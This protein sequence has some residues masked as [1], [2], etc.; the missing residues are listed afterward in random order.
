MGTIKSNRLDKIST[1][2]YRHKKNTYN[3]AGKINRDD[4]IFDDGWSTPKHI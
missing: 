2:G 4:N 1:K 3:L